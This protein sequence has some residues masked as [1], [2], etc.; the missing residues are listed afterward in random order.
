[1]HNTIVLIDELELH[2]HG[3]WQRRLLQYLRQQNNQSDR[4]NQLIITTHSPALMQAVPAAQTFELGE[5]MTSS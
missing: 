4:N 5:L 1:M 2:L 3:T